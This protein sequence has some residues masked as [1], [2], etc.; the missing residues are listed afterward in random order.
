MVWGAS[1]SEVA[2]LG[3]GS[4]HA[5]PRGATS[6][7]SLMPDWLHHLLSGMGC[8]WPSS[9]RVVVIAWRAGA[10]SKPSERV[11][12]MLVHQEVQ[13]RPLRPRHADPTPT[14]PRQ[15]DSPHAPQDRSPSPST[16]R[17]AVVLALRAC[18]EPPSHGVCG[19]AITWRAQARSPRP[20]HVGSISPHRQAGGSRAPRHE[21]PQFPGS[22]NG[23][24]STVRASEV[25]ALNVVHACSAE[26]CNFAL[27]AHALP[28]SCPGDDDGALRDDDHL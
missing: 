20:R 13:P 25:A 18:V 22:V 27:P 8:C 12:P 24:Y 6:F 10:R 11:P 4:A 26:G 23:C 9:L 14:C 3:A 28:A 2:A 21:L 1:R 16:R 7:P 19:A 15:S 5:R 17:R